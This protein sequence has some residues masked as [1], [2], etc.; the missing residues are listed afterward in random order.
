MDHIHQEVNV[1]IGPIFENFSHGIEFEVKTKFGEEYDKEVSSMSSENKEATLVFGLKLSLTNTEK[2]QE[3]IDTLSQL[4]DMA[5]ETIPDIK[6]YFETGLNIT[7]RN[8]GS[9]IF[10]NCEVSGE[11]AKKF[12][13]IPG[14][15]KLNMSNFSFCG[16]Q[17][18]KFSTGFDPTR[19]LD[20]E[21]DNVFEMLTLFRV[22]GRGRFEDIHNLIDGSKSM[23]TPYLESI[24][25]TE[26]QLSITWNFVNI[27][28]VMRSF[29][30]EFKYDPLTIKKVVGELMS[31]SFENKA[32]Q[33]LSEYQMFMN[34]Y[35]EQ[36]KMMAQWLLDHILKF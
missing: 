5:A 28:T 3:A 16:K 32:Q 30:H 24:G 21:L 10:I 27:L 18:I 13:S 14:W 4:K 25:A 2:A 36:A 17:D 34:E 8:D 26:K 6:K 33:I 20:C 15:N 29:G 12:D 11:V 1:D 9:N 31:I 35:F 22:E 19:I 23:I 7:F